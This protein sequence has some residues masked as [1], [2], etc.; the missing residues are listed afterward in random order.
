MRYLVGCD[1]GTSGTKSVV[2]DEEGTVLGIHYI[3]YP[4][5]FPKVGYAEHDPLDYWNAVKNT[6]KSAIQQ[7]NVDAKDIKGVSVSALAP[8]CILVDKNLQTLQMCH[9]WMDRRCAEEAEELKET[10]GEDRIFKLSANPIDSYYAAV[11]LLWEKKHRPE[12][13]NKTYKLQTV[14]DYPVMKLTGKAITDYSSASL[15][16]IAF[17]IVNRKWD[18]KLIEEVGLDGDK[19]PEPYPC[20][21]VIG[22]VTGEAAEETGLAKGTPVVAGTVDANAAW[23]AAGMLNDGDTQLVMGTAGCFG[24][25]HKEP[26]FTRNMIT[27]VHTSNSRE[28]YTTLAATTGF[29]ALTRYYRD[30]FGQMEKDIASK[31]NIDVFEMMNLAA[32]KSPPGANGLITLPYFSGERTPIWDPWARGVIFGMSLAHNKGDLLRSF[33]EGAGFAIRHNYEYMK[34]SGVKMN[35][36]V[37][38][39]EGGAQSRLWRQIISDMLRVPVVYM[40]D[41][42]GAPVGNALNAGIGVGVF[43]DYSVVK[44]WLKVSDSHEPNEETA[45]RY[46]SYYE[47]FRNVYEDVKGNYSKLHKT[48]V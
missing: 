12:L 41:L 45:Q 31:L 14:A 11:K 32:A 4:L 10:I 33:M 9:I 35:M 6:M 24:V 30:T 48:L 5:H 21:E 1:L 17:D 22:E 27:I 38:L 13:Y 2:L 47:L 34:T 36:P 44:N 20:D 7:S 37:I 46:D 19:F 26:K 29:G 39:S 8:G 42:K 23:L 15:I 16:G 18:Y 25:C 43:K 28:Y 40:K 3:E